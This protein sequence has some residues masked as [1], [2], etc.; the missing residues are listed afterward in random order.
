MKQQN[1]EL[2]QQNDE[3]RQQNTDN[4]NRIEMLYIQIQNLTIEN[5]SLK[6]LIYS[7]REVNEILKR[8]AQLNLATQNEHSQQTFEQLNNSNVNLTIQN[9]QLQQKLNELIV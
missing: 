3:L 7:V 2:K 5:E 9:K 1:D 4:I 8:E 6:T